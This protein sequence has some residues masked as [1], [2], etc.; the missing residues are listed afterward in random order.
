M[1]FTLND[2]FDHEL[3]EFDGVSAGDALARSIAH[4]AAALGDDLVVA[5]FAASKCRV[6]RVQGNDGISYILRVATPPAPFALY[7]QRNDKEP[8]VEDRVRRYGGAL[9]EDVTRI[10]IAPA[11]DFEP[12]WESGLIDDYFRG[13]PNAR[14]STDADT[15]SRLLKLT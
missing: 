10:I 12:G 13:N 11:I 8:K 2:F 3:C 5:I 1:G 6:E 15:L 9:L 4:T 14:T 7:L